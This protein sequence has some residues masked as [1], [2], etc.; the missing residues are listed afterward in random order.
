MNRECTNFGSIV[1]HQIGWYVHP[2]GTHECNT[3]C[4]KTNRVPFVSVILVEWIQSAING[5]RRSVQ[6]KQAR[7]QTHKITN[8]LN[9]TPNDRNGSVFY[10][11]S[12]NKVGTFETCLNLRH[13]YKMNFCSN[14]FISS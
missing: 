2:L 13:L 5:N 9:S 6:C 12:T 7:E 14:K 1:N 8:A 11:F 10:L 3:L 4:N